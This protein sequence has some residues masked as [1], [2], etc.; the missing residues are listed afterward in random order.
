MKAIRL[1]QM[2]VAVTERELALTVFCRPCTIHGCRPLSV[3]SQPAV[4]MRNG[5]ITAHIESHRK[6]RDRPR[7]TP[8]KQPAA[9]QCQEQDQRS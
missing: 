9:P 8:E 2:S 6:T 1:I 5:V 3:S 4:F 7:R